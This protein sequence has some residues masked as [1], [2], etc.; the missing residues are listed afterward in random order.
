LTAFAPRPIRIGERRPKMPNLIW[1]LPL[2]SHWIFPRSDVTHLEVEVNA[3]LFRCLH[4]ARAWLEA[5]PEPTLEAQRFRAQGKLLVHTGGN[6]S[7]GAH[8][9]R[10]FNL[11][12]SPEAIDRAAFHVSRDSVWFEVTTTHGEIFMTP[13]VS[14]EAIPSPATHDAPPDS[15]ERTTHIT[16]ALEITIKH[17]GEFD[18]RALEELIHNLDAA[19]NGQRDSGSLAPEC[20]DGVT[21][22]FVFRLLGIQEEGNS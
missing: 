16:L 20:V 15:T 9:T 13:Q 17:E 12:P 5:S 19:L 1:I 18:N 10:P 4:L 3:T 11:D 22:F 21:E 8:P 14:F 6:D 2:E 7:T